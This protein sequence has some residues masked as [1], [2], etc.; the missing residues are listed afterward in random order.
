METVSGGYTGVSGG[1]RF[2]LAVIRAIRRL[3]GKRKVSGGYTGGSGGYM[4][5]F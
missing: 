1:Y 2:N 4:E 3:Y 5:F